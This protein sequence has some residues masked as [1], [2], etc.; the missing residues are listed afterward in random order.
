MFDQMKVVGYSTSNAIILLGTITIVI[1]IYIIK[2]FVCVLAWISHKSTN[3]GKQLFE[4]LK[5]EVFYQ[6]LIA[7]TLEAFLELC[8]SG[9]L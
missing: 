1:T 8:I 5:Y 2:F 7:I 3:K 9:Y 6:D 4:K